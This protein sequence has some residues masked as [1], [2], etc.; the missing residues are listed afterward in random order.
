METNRE[1]RVLQERYSL[2]RQL[3]QGG[4]GE[5]WL[6]TD[7]ESGELV[8]VKHLSLKDTERWK[9][10]ELFEREGEVLAALDHEQVPDYV[11]MFAVL[12]EERAEFYLVQEFIDG[13]TLAEE[14]SASGCWTQ[15]KAIEDLRAMLELLV[16]LQAR[17]PPVIHRDIKPSNIMRR[18]SDERLVLIDFGA[19]Q[20]AGTDASHAST[21]V[22]TASYMAFEQMS[23]RALPASDVYSLGIS[24]CQLITGTPPSQVEMDGT[25]LGYASLLRE[26]GVSGRL[27]EVLERMI[28]LSLNER[29]PNARAALR[30]LDREVPGAGQVVTLPMPRGGGGEVEL[31]I[32]DLEKKRALLAQYGDPASLR[33][34]GFFKQAYIERALTDDLRK[35]D[36]FLNDAR[37]QGFELSQYQDWYGFPLKESLLLSKDALGIAHL[38]R[39]RGTKNTSNQQEN[40]YHYYDEIFTLF[41]DGHYIVTRKATSGESCEA[42]RIVVGTGDFYRD[43]REHMRAVRRYAA[44]KRARVVADLNLE[45]IFLVYQGLLRHTSV[46]NRV[47][48]SAFSFGAVVLWGLLTWFYQRSISAGNSREPVVESWRLTDETF[49]RMSAGQDPHTVRVKLDFEGYTEELTEELAE[50]RAVS[51]TLAD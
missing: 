46:G 42:Y 27:L 44:Q 11:E 21:F 47:M 16:W 13:M 5:T 8:V 7:M 22:G 51:V 1:A 3:G 15:Q 28:Q 4:Q 37:E 48:L 36:G 23:G 29:Y 40:P 10:I 14:L 12:D 20:L 43:Y 9:Q 30:A 6:A 39:V 26:Q 31:E 38:L 45:E 19:V 32:V 2:S 50:E 24:M 17:V 33:G 25:S 41:E 18:A 35:V 34:F 49:S